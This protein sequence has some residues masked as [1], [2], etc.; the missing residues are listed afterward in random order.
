[1]ETLLARRSIRID[2]VTNCFRCAIQISAFRN[3]SVVRSES[4]SEAVTCVARDYVNVH[5]TDFLAGRSAVG[6]KDVDP[7]AS[8]SASAHCICNN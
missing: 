6:E 1:M 4:E 8:D 7:F 5:V 3:A 2:R